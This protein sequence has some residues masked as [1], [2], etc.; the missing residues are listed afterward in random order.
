MIALVVAIVG[1]F[2]ADMS[3]AGRK[4][5]VVSVIWMVAQTFTLAKTIRDKF[6]A[7]LLQ[8]VPKFAGG[9]L[10]VVEGTRAWL[11]QAVLLFAASVVF[12]IHS[13][14]AHVGVAGTSGG[15]GGGGWT[16]GGGLAV[17]GAAFALVASVYLAKTVRDRA[18]AEL[19]AGL[20]VPGRFDKL[21]AICSGTKANFVVVVLGLV[22]ALG[23]TLGG[24]WSMPAEV[25]AVERK[26]FILVAVLFMTASSPVERSPN[27]SEH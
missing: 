9:L 27:A 3:D 23:A 17:L 20:D 7:E 19:F 26:G 22:G 1:A 10:G 6:L 11:L 13:L 15:G 16:S 14:K 5:F 4:L 18:D 24:A 25:V 21:V 12:V 8:D 2:Q